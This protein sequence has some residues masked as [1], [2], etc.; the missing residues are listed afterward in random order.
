[1]NSSSNV[2]PHSQA[3]Y[4][5]QQQQPITLATVEQHQGTVFPSP[6]FDAEADCHTLSK[7]MKGAG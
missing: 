2:T 3:F 1:M 4:P 6:N 7:A 5:Q